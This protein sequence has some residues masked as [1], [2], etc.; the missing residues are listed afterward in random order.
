MSKGKGRRLVYIP[1]ELIEGALEASRKRGESIG[2]FVEVTLRQA[3]R[4]SRLNYSP[5]RAGD[6][7][8]VMHVQRILGGAFVPID[9]LD[10]LITKAYRDERELLQAKWYE[11]GRWH[12]KYIREKFENPAQALKTF[13]E[14]TRWDLGEVAVKQNGN[15]VKLRC[16]ST[17]LTA[18]ATELLSKFI[19]G[20]MHGMGY[21]TEDADNMKGMITLQFIM[22]DI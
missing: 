4:T 5:E 20:A 9:V 22:P 21:E 8:E 3:I 14:A 7:L 18:E 17:V 2:K 6:L 16:V 13:L 10:Y 15:R 19:E 1:E 12:G 11:S